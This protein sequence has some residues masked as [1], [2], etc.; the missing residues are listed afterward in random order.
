MSFDMMFSLVTGCQAERTQCCRSEEE[1]GKE[2]RAGDEV[3]FFLPGRAVVVDLVHVLVVFIA[4]AVAVLAVV[5]VLVLVVFVA[6]AVLVVAVAVVVVVVVVVVNC[7]CCCCEE[8][9][10]YYVKL[11]NVVLCLTGG[12]SEKSRTS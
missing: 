4:V 5:L 6:V 9:A 1:G 3:S 11:G 8:V 7:C 12:Q 10:R 2:G